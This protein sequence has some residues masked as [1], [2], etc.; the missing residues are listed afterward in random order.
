MECW[1][2]NKIKDKGEVSMNFKKTISLLVVLFL[3]GSYVPPKDVMAET[4]DKNTAIVDQVNLEYYEQFEVELEEI[5]DD[6]GVSENPELEIELENV[7]ADEFNL[8]LNYE[9][10]DLEVESKVSMD[11]ETE[12]MIINTNYVNDENEQIKQEFE[13]IVEESTGDKFIADVVDL[14]TG[15]RFKI[16]S[17]EVQASALPAIIIG[18]IIRAGAR[19]AISLYSRTQLLRALTSVTFSSAKLQKKFKHAAD[20]GVTG[21]YSKANALKFETALRNHVSK[22]THIYR[23]KI[24]GQS[25]HVILH[26]RGN[27]GAFF[28]KNGDF[29]SGWKLNTNQLNYHKNVGE[30][31]IKR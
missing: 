30:L 22:S 18:F 3:I 2:F 13:I 21:N 8:E 23:T 25:D 17:E 20:F 14:E 29:I 12:E 19:A 16:D 9:S 31:I 6:L 1:S 7:T 27:T 15:E 11:F 10:S 4:F 26:L 24:S 5:N 28:N